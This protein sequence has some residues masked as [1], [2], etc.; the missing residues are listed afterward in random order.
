MNIQ[1]LKA[2]YF[3]ESQSI[4][5]LSKTFNKS[6]PIVTKAINSLLEQ[7]LIEESGFA[8]STGGRRAIQFKVNNNLSHHMLVIVLDQFYT[9]IHIFNI[10]NKVIAQITDQY[11]PLACSSSALKKHHSLYRT[12]SR[13]ISNSI[14]R[15]YGRRYQYAWICR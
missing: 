15:F 4:A 12:I 14:S 8:V 13:S 3:Q 1:I 11:N 6:I 10:E 9:S 7:K 2:L 5:Q